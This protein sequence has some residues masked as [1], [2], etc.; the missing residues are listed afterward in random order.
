L[1]QLHHRK[2]P[3]ILL[4]LSL[5]SEW[6]M[7]AVLLLVMSGLIDGASILLG[8]PGKPSLLYMTVLAGK[9]VLVAVMLGLAAMNRFRLMPKGQDQ[10]IARNA[11]LE[12]G[13]GVTVVLLAGVL[14]QLQPTL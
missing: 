1:I 9:L 2:E 5:F 12:L 4:A 6:A 3:N 8:A 10:I 13:A 14:G 7:I 11:A